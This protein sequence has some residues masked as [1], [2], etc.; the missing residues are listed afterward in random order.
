MRSVR[1][2]LI[3]DMSNPTFSYS[4]SKDTFSKVAYLVLIGYL[5]FVSIIMIV[6]G[7]R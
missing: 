3:T 4:F 7:L 2:F 1:K 6:D 5:F